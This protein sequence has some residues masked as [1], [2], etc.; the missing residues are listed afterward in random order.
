MNLMI[1]IIPAESKAFHH[2][3]G[4]ENEHKKDE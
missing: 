2:F 3:S 1:Q 4:P